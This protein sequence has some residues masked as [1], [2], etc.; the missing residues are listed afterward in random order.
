[1]VGKELDEKVKEKR[2]KGKES[3]KGKKMEERSERRIGNGG[4]ND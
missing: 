1:M 4:A 3:G 2:R